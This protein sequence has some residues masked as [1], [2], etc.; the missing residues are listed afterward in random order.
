MTLRDL[1]KPKLAAV[2]GLSVSIFL[3]GCTA[4]GSSF[5]NNNTDPRLSTGSEAEFFSKSGFQACAAGAGVAAVACLLSNS[6]NKTACMIIGGIAACGV[7]LG[8]NYYVDG[9]RAQFADTNVR[10]QHMTTEVEEDTRRIMA[11][12]QTFKDIIKDDEKQLAQVQQQLAQKS[13]DA[14]QAKNELAQLDRNINAMNKE[15]AV[16]D[17]KVK[18]YRDAANIEKSDGANAAKIAE[19]N[20]QINAMEQ[21]KQKVQQLLLAH[22]RSRNAIRLG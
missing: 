5:L 16:M 11:R 21:E 15:L 12:T 17:D 13:I 1:L 14:V 2:L 19:L 4:T 22:T 8:A 3:S 18:Q 10:L 9:R 7:G 6:G 20:K